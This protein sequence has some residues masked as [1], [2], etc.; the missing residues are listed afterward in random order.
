MLDFL[1]TLDTDPEK[2][3][4]TKCGWRQIKKI[5]QGEDR[6]TLQTLINNNTITPE[7]Q[8]TATHALEA[9]QSC[10]KDEEHFWH[11]MDEIMSDFCQQPNEL[12]HALNTRI[13]TM[14][15]NCRFK[16]HQTTQTIKLML[17]QHA[18]KFHEARDWI[19]LKTKAS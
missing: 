1:E 15:N 11:F 4:Q 10:I 9:I 7:D 5:F 18:T 17:L 2:E 3:D 14:V 6:Q 13:T 19:R 12:I 16:D 8:L